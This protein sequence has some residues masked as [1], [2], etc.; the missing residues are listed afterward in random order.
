M[1]NIYLVNTD[2]T[3]GLLTKLKQID[4]NHNYHIMAS[5]DAE[6]I[7]NYSKEN[8]EA[9][10]KYI[11]IDD[12]LIK[13]K[14]QAC[15]RLIKLRYMEFNF[16]N[17]SYSTDN[18]FSDESLSSLV[19]EIIQSIDALPFNNVLQEISQKEEQFRQKIRKDEKHLQEQLIEFEKLILNSLETPNKLNDEEIE[20]LCKNLYKE[21]LFPYMKK[22]SKL[23]KIPSIKIIKLGSKESQELRSTAYPQNFEDYASKLEKS[24]NCS[25]VP[26]IYSKYWD[27]LA[28]SLDIPFCPLGGTFVLFSH[29][30]TS[31]FFQSQISG[32]K[33]KNEMEQKFLNW[34]EQSLNVLGTYYSRRANTFYVIKKPDELKIDLAEKEVYFRYDDEEFY[35]KNKVSLPVW[36]YKTPVTDLKIDDFLFLQNAD[37]KAV[38]IRKIGLERLVEFGIV[39]DSYENYPDNEMWAKSEYKIIDMHKVIPPKRFVDR[40]GNLQG[41]PK[42]F[43]YAPYLYM[44]NQTTGTYHL[45]GLHPRCKTLYDAI[46]MRYN[47][48]NID[49][50]EIK[51]IR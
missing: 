12:H 27:I 36:L 26:D 19:M 21:F 29:I 31:I 17:N 23:S 39:V 9:Y 28:Q 32:L 43:K 5:N 1:N 7:C 24:L 42:L 35:Y 18:F 25:Y 13:A 45:E 16:N 4:K 48:L 37:A 22:S 30:A 47:G 34:W 49:N 6:Y 50:Y 10:K 44:K 14:I 38:F 33:P 3:L 20:N 51:G 46:K 11:S 41:K 15:K 8:E 40:F 2:D